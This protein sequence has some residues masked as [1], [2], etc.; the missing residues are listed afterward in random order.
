MHCTT[1]DGKR[2]SATP[3]LSKVTHRKDVGKIH[4]F[5]CSVWPCLDNAIINHS[6]IRFGVDG[7][8]KTHKQNRG[9]PPNPAQDSIQGSG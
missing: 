5:G 8:I 9:T 7:T 6:R 4:P 1:N 2:K 3:V